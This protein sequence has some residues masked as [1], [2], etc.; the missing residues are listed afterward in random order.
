MTMLRHATLAIGV[1]L[2][3]CQAN[4]SADTAAPQSVSTAQTVAGTWHIEFRLDSV[5]EGMT[6]RPSSRNAVASGELVIADE[7]DES[8]LRDATMTVSFVPLLHHEMSCFAPGA[9]KIR[10]TKQQDE[11]LV[12]F[13]PNAADCGFGTIL[14]PAEGALAGKWDETSLI[15]PVAA[16]AVT[17]VR[18]AD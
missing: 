9:Q 14:R 13:T 11:W 17:M 18:S 10:L 8:G 2:A 1:L 12:Q 7:D 3:G 16:G 6:W 15:G 5:R 4:G